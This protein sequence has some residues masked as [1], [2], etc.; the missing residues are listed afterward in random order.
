M[1]SGKTSLLDRK[2]PTLVGLAILIGGLA[3]GVFF[4]GDGLGVFAPRATPQTTPKQIKITNI[5]DT[6]FTVSFMTDEVTTGFL[7]YGTRA[8]QLTTQVSDDRD[9][10]AGNVG[11]YNTHHITVRSLQPQ[12][13]YYFTLGTSSNA[14]FDNNGEPFTV[15]TH[16][17]LGNLTLAQTIYG[18]V[19]TE[20][21]TPADGSMVYVSI[22]GT[23]ELSTLVR[24]SGTWAIPLSQARTPAGTE[25]PPI[26]ADTAMNVFAQGRQVSSTATLQTKVGQPQL[27]VET[28]TLGK[29]SIANLGTSATDNS[30]KGGGLAGTDTEPEFTST[31][32]ASV[33][34]SAT[35]SPTPLPSATTRPI[36]SASAAP[37][38]TPATTVSPTP[39]VS[40]VTLPA[41]DSAQPVSGSFE[42]TLVLL[43]FGL[44]FVSFGSFLYLSIRRE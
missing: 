13:T 16:P 30:I 18:T 27:P 37:T 12:T 39:K 36:A 20:A 22:E 8:N 35:P 42:N 24:S 5:T 41:T 11:T 19:L 34:P 6:S 21:S 43:V 17:K 23:G 29:N 26:T 4:L 15:K 40:P 3:A 38:A 7:K 44:S 14:A 1:K 28:I 9:Q 31:P 10:L 25:Q 33:D 32:S 2:F